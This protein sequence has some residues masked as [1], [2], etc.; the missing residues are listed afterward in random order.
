MAKEQ[1]LTVIIVS[2]DLPMVARYCDRIIMLHDHRI[3]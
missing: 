2:H 3:Y 1:G